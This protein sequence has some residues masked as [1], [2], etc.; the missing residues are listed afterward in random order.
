MPIIS[1]QD[2]HGSL[3]YTRGLSVHPVQNTFITWQTL[4]TL[5][6]KHAKGEHLLSTSCAGFRERRCQERSP[7]AVA[8]MVLLL[9][10][11]SL[12]LP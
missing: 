2:T 9:L 5:I 3:F 6:L 11:R 1:L 10:S 8:S 7:E 12:L 4:I